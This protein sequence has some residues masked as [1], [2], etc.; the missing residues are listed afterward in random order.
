LLEG[1]D[2]TN[3]GKVKDW[4]NTGPGAFPGTDDALLG[5]FITSGSDWVQRVLSRN[6]A[7]ATYTLTRNGDGG[8]TLCMPQF[9]IISVSSVKVNG[10]AIAAST[11]PT[12]FG[13]TFDEGYIY[14]LGS[15]F[16][17]GIQNVAIT[18]TA[19]FQVTDEAFTSP[20]SGALGVESFRRGWVSDVGLKFASTGAALTRV[21]TTPAANQYQIT[22]TNYKFSYVFNAADANK[23]MLITYGYV[24]EALEMAVVELVGETYKRRSHI[25]QTSQNIG[26]GM[27][28]SFSQKDVNETVKTLLDQYQ[29]VVPG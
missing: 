27:V 1:T 23:A 25:G 13:Y 24:P 9:P 18:Y 14:L 11:G 22:T 17:R 21:S 29:N 19:G 28:V 7:P 15:N 6:I 26:Q 4:L 20:A 10:V 5:R 12:S 16:W 2:L 8:N 3:L